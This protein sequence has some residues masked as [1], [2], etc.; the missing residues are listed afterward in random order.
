MKQKVIATLTAL[1]MGI[2]FVPTF[3]LALEIN[4]GNLENGTEI[5]SERSAQELANEMSTFVNENEINNNLESEKDTYIVSEEDVDISIPKDGD[6]SIIMGDELKNNQ[7]EM[8]LP[9][10][11]KNV[12]A[13]KTD[14][15][16][17]IYNPPNENMSIGVQVLSV[18]EEKEQWSAIRVLITI[19]NA[20]ANKE[21]G[22][23]YNLPYGYKLI[24]AEDWYDEFIKTD[25][26]SMDDFVSSGEIY[27]ISKDGMIIE[28]IEP[29]WAYDANNN[30]I[31]THYDIR[32][33]ELVQVVEFDEN[34]AFPVIADPTKHPNKTVIKKIGKTKVKEIRD[35]YSTS[36]RVNYI[37]GLFSLGSNF[38]VPQIGV[39]WTLASFAGTSYYTKNYTLWNDAYVSMLEKSKTEI[40]VTVTYKWHSGKRC[41]YPLSNNLK[42]SL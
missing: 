14:N 36:K 6:G 5:N 33:D 20:E 22:F 15:G 10:E 29:A 31:P 4:D 39:P 1:I 32:G 17:I 12:D 37:L 9:N 35:S 26:T 38:V 2:T 25:E 7:T 8:K 40:K 34:T 27:V 18:G 16:T 3:S 21:Y 42:F 19:D 24:K 41:Y 11:V 23:K 28:T 30:L 13:E